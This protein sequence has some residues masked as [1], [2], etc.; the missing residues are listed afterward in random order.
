MILLAFF[1]PLAVYLLVL[2]FL[3]RLRHPT[4]VSG[5]WDG[6]ALLFG[7]SGFLLFSGP[8]VLSALS[9]KWRMFWL[10]GKGEAPLAG[11]DGVWQF[12]VFLSVLYFVLIL[13]GAAYFFW[14]QRRLTAVYCAEVEQVE[15]A[16]AAICERLDLHPVRSGGLFLFGLSLGG[17]PERRS[18]NIERIQA[19]HYLPTAV[20]AAGSIAREIPAASAGATTDRIVLEQSAILEV[21]GF[22]LMHH[23]TL[24]WDPVDSPLRQV[25]ETELRQ[26]L[27]E[28]STDDN[29]LGSWLIT[30][31]SILLAFELIGAFFLIVLRLLVR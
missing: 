28:T 13:A 14:R 9:E 26:R 15:N 4:L 23:V 19:P 30:L 1:F 5:I 25:L 3:N 12:W 21:D 8:A 10:F 2:G 22:P 16:L 7:V 31:G 6:V 17:T 29:N 20:R 18:S 27:L 11:A 24:R